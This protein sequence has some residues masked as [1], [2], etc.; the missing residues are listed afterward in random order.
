MKKVV[1]NFLYQALFQVLTIIM[2]MIT[3]PIVSRALGAEGIGEWGFANSIVNYFLL[4]A[5]LGMANYAV[6]EIAFVR[7]D[8][9]KLSEKFWE[10]Q[11]FNMFFSLTIIIVY[12]LFILIT[13]Q[14]Y[15][16]LIQTLMLL[17]VFFDI[18]WLFQGVEDF[19]KIAVRSM[20]LRLFSVGLIVA[21]VRNTDDLWIYALILSTSNLLAAIVLWKPAFQHIHFKKVRM[22]AIW[23]HFRPALNFFILKISA[24]IFV[25]LNKTLLGMMTTMV[26]VGYFTNAL[27]LIVLLGT[28]IG[29]LNKVMLPRMSHL[30]RKG[31]EEEFIKVLQK[32]IHVQLFVTIAMMFGM[33]AINDKLIGWFLGEDFYFVK[34]LIPIL[35]PVLV[36][37]QL[38][39]AIA[40]QYLVPKD[41]MKFYNWTMIIG[42]LIN[43]ATSLILI[44]RI[45]VYGAVFGFLIGQLFLGTSRAIVL[46]KKSEFRFDW[47]R[48][49][50]WLISGAL[51][52]LIILITTN[53]MSATLLTTLIQVVIG[54]AI[55]TG[56]TTILKVN[57]VYE[58]IKK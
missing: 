4:V 53:A 1:H 14:N 51:M 20:I 6:R 44:P 15:L 3:I 10:L 28:V 33:I 19:K 24:T 21:F 32:T 11:L 36:F 25:N 55:Y 16:Y 34:N 41:E 18:S 43:V 54:M 47:I 37:K 8:R 7:N 26:L 17:G 42:T 9:E 38:H 27:Q 29:A 30:Q 39:Q 2:P 31:N 56:L 58:L 13:N 48:I 57:P 49:S 50:K 23:S 12:L 40:N 52:L 5:G 22:R 46:V 35:A 45:R